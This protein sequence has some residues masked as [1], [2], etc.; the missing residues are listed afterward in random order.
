MKEGK[1]FNYKYLIEK[2]RKKKFFFDR[3]VIEDK[4]EKINE[5]KK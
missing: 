1:N 2:F 5:L 3:K 4:L